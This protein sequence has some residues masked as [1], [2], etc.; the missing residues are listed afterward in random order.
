MEKTLI[1]KRSYNVGDTIEKLCAVCAEERNH[2]VASVSKRNQITRVD[3][4]KCGTRSTFKT[5]EETSGATTRSK[6]NVPYDRER[7]YRTGQIMLHPTY[8]AGE[9]TAVIEGRKID[10]LFADRMRRLVHSLAA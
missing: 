9:V 6:P 8:G 7:T 2:V 4:P 1:E 10:V 5:A 3:C